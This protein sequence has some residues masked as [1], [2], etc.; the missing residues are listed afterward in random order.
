MAHVNTVLGPIHPDE[1]GPTGTH[2]HVV[3]GPPGWEFDPEWWFHYPHVFAK[4]LAGLVEYRELGGRSIVCCSGNGMGRDIEFYRLLSKYSGVNI[5]VPSGFWAAAGVANHFAG[6]DIDYYR[7]LF[8]LE[9]TQGVG[10]SGI[11]PGFI[12]VGIGRAMTA[13]DELLH[14][15]AAR[16]AKI[17]GVPVVSHGAWEALR[18]LEVLTDEGLDPS[19][20]IMSHCSHGGAID[21]VRDRKVASLGA[22]ISYDSFTVTNTSAVTHYAHPDERRAE[23]VKE[24]L[25][26]GFKHR[27]LLSSDNNLFSLGWMRSS[28]YVG[29]GTTADFLRTTPGKLRRLGVPEEVFWEILTENPK[30]VM[31]I[32]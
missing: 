11:R 32:A 3:W 23:A 26:A 10:K 30:Q 31:T 17:T 4:C 2:E 25:D 24:M 9:I 8:V 13:G 12:K 21:P 29:K 6:R 14:R 28:P 18:V 20:V 5:V 15:A 19:R 16:A 22:W 1:L 27:I 7:D